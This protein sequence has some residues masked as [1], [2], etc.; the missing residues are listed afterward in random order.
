M[1]RGAA[2]AAVST[3]GGKVLLRR[4]AGSLPAAR[5]STAPATPLVE[6]AA[7][8]RPLSERSIGAGSSKPGIASPATST[9]GSGAGSSVM[10]STWSGRWRS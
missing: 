2:G 9:G 4:L 7:E 8:T 10:V 1:L 6:G 5:A 3:G